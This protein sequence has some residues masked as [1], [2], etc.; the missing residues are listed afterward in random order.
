MQE[1]PI[2]ARLADIRIIPTD[3]YQLDEPLSRPAR[4]AA[5]EPDE[6]EKKPQRAPENGLVR[7]EEGEYP[8]KA[9]PR[10]AGPRGEGENTEAAPPIVIETR[11]AER[12]G[13]AGIERRPSDRPA[14]RDETFETPVVN[15]TIGRVEVRAVTSSPPAREKKARPQ[16]VNLDEYLS[17]RSS[18]GKR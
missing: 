5:V 18:G 1:K 17:R 4:P 11:V 16:T 12:A 9:A 10:A 2:P 8:K 3:A 15:V 6:G 7:A 14:P 13:P